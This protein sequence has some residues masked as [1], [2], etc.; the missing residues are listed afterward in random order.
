MKEN[1]FEG[2]SFFSINLFL[3]HFSLMSPFLSLKSFQNNL[4]HCEIIT[5]STNFLLKYSYKRKLE[6]YFLGTRVLAL[7]PVY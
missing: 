5:N 4:M 7:K 2:S 3:S 6:K 1:T